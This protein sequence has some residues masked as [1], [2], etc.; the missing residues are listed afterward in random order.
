MTAFGYDLWDDGPDAEDGFRDPAPPPAPARRRTVYGYIYELITGDPQDGLHPYVGMTERTIHQRVHGPSG[1]TSL[2]SIAMDPWKAR[3]RPGRAGYRCLERVYDTG[4]PEEN[5]RALR[6]AE[7]FWIDRL[8]S[9]HNDVRP[10]RPP[11]HEPQPRRAVRPTTGRVVARRR[12]FSRIPA[13]VYVFLI[14]A[15]SLTGLA[16]RFVL[17]MHLPWPAAPWVVA[18][19]VGVGFAWR[20]FWSF[21]RS[22]RRLMRKSRR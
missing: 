3:I 9:T 6:R 8:R 15:A 7:A 19:I 16:A 10:V 21:H 12:T 2:E 1:H 13:R 5:D 14:L 18:P 4:D 11:L 20:I 17:A 22:A